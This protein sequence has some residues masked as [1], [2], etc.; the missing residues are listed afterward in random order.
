[1]S[2]KTDQWLEN[3]SDY[4]STRISLFT[5]WYGSESGIQ[6][7]I[8]LALGLKII[9]IA[10]IYYAIYRFLRFVY[11]VAPTPEDGH[12]FILAVCGIV[13]FIWAWIRIAIV[14]QKLLKRFR[15]LKREK[16]DIPL[17][18]WSRDAVTYIKQTRA[19]IAYWDLLK[20]LTNFHELIASKLFIWTFHSL[21]E[22]ELGSH[23]Q[24]EF[25][26]V[27]VIP[28]ELKERHSEKVVS[29]YRNLAQPIAALWFLI[30]LY[31][32][33]W[34][35]SPIIGLILRA[36]GLFGEVFSGIFFLLIFFFAI[37]PVVGT[38][39]VGTL[40]AFGKRVEL[41]WLPPVLSHQEPQQ[42]E[43]QELKEHLA[44]KMDELM[45]ATEKVN[46]ANEQLHQ[47]TQALAKLRELDPELAGQ[48]GILVNMVLEEE[49]A[50]A[51]IAERKKAK[52][53]LFKDIII[54][55]VFFVLG[56]LIT[57]DLVKS[58]I[59]KITVIMKNFGT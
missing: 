45:V 5:S 2:K 6:A 44:L 3:A 36:T 32:T 19:A 21:L 54:G 7:R 12:E 22:P 41:W 47:K 46:N 27:G 55:T 38:S 34:I 24:A 17:K 4:L 14:G 9:F 30:T 58:L 26:S 42:Q 53:D 40:I 39:F 51:D 43:Y 50:K 23:S 52:I 33:L 18:L 28:D 8:L 20:R 25:F 29:R 57:S 13:A 48:V 31:L 35:L 1:M 15:V 49:H 56:L 11:S 16:I 59:A 10:C 37:F